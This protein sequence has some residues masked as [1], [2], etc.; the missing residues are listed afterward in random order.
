MLACVVG[1]GGGEGI[2][3]ISETI[4]QQKGR[5]PH[6]KGDPETKTGLISRQV[7]VQRQLSV[8]GD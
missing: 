7:C 6:R 1:E 2:E 5:T 3:T 4:P 8:E